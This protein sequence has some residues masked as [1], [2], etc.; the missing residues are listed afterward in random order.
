MSK[1]TELFKA[2]SKEFKSIRCITLTAMLAAVS[3]ALGSL[4][5]QFGE[6]LKV[7]FTFLPNEF[8]Y[9][10]FGP[11]VGVIYGAVIDVLNFMVKP[12]G[13]FYF[14]FTLSSMLTGLI[15][16]LILYRRPIRLARVILANIIRTVFVDMLLNTLWLTQLTGNSFMVMLPTRLIK[17][18][19]MLPIETVLL[20]SLIK[21]VEASGIIRKLFPARNA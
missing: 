18:L 2:S 6:I 21:S 20:Y 8:A 17:L 16:G 5:V 12:T 4:T 1:F 7:G 10:L 15:Y 9:Y 3:V 19:I 13:A 14:G 11:V